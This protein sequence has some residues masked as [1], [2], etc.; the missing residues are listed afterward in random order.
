MGANLRIM[1]FA[2]NGFSAGLSEDGS[3]FRIRNE[4]WKEE[5][6]LVAKVTSLGGW[7]DLDARRLTAP[8]PALAAALRDI[9]RAESFEPLPVLRRP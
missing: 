6:T 4:F 7:L 8:P 9:T 5:G 3:R 1:Y 2:V